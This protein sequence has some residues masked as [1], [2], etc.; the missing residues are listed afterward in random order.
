MQKSKTVPAKKAAEQSLLKGAR[1]R[2][3]QIK[4]KVM[5][6]KDKSVVAAVKKLALKKTAA[7]KKP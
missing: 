4:E 6:V 1:D 3:E 5:S 7:K 2:M